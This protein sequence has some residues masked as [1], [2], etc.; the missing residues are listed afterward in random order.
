MRLFPTLSSPVA[1]L[2]AWVLFSPACGGNDSSGGNGVGGSGTS[3][4]GRGGTGSGGTGGNTTTPATGGAGGG[5]VS[6]GG[7]GGSGA[8]GGSGG[9]AGGGGGPAPAD[10]GSTDAPPSSGGSVTAVCN[11]M[12]DAAKAFLAGIAGDGNKPMQ[13]ALPFEMRRHFKYTPGTRPGL[14][15]ASMTM[16]QRT[17]ALALVRLALSDSGYQ[18][19]EQ[20]RQLEAV[21]R[22]L[23][24]SNSRDPLGYFL[25]IYGTPAPDGDWAFHWEGHHLSLHFTLSKCTAVADAPSFFGTNPARVAMQVAGGPPMGT[26]VLAK[27]EDLARA[28]AT[29]LSADPQKRAMAI[30][31]TQR[32][33]QDSPARVNPATPAGLPVSAMASAEVEQL[34][35]LVAEYVQNL[36]PDL[37]AARL[38]RIQ[39]ADFTKVTFLWN[40]ALPSG[41]HYYRIQGPTFMIEYLNSQNAANHVH[42]VWRDF[43]GDFGDDLL[44]LHLKEFPH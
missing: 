13:A 37:A 8:P 15:L 28:L 5:S 6:T 24:G 35:T 44:A 23:E 1:V 9:G 26:R 22:E 18:K 2:A 4:G 34:K 31:G 25:A 30:G 16:P 14:N 7:Q 27:E 40:G 21:L 20:I 11:Q 12:V 36:S 41:A 32:D 17:Q 19:A 29:A 42:S 33:V 39:D 10:G 38:K 3:V 43:N